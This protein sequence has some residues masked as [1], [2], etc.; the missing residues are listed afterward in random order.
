MGCCNC[1]C[2]DGEE[3]CK[4]PGE[5]G[6]CCSSD[7]CCG[8]SE[9]PIC[10][11]ELDPIQFCCEDVI[12]CNDGQTCCGSGES[13]TCCSEGEYCCDGECQ[14]EEC[15]EDE[16]DTAEDCPCVAIGWTE[17][18]GTSPRACCPPGY[19]SIGEGFCDNGVDV[20]QS[21]LLQELVQC[22]DGECI[23][24]LDPCPP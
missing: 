4:A 20:V 17:A 11:S 6:I 13:A 2:P 23:S 9:E 18:E 3:C 12:C 21:S 22:C 7:R 15:G 1:C 16:C 5:N 8:T 24:A 19:E 10:C 14:E